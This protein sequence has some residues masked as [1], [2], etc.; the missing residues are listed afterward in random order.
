MMLNTYIIHL[1]KSTA[2]YEYIT[3]LLYRYDFLNVE[4]IDAVDGRL[5]DDY[6]IRKQFNYTKSYHRYGRTLNK[7]EIGCALSHRKCYE[8]IILS[9]NE[10]ALVLEDDISI[11]R[12]LRV[13]ID[14]RPQIDLIMN[15][16][17][18]TICFLSG[19]YWFWEGREGITSVFSAVGAYAYL[20]NKAAARKILEQDKTY[21]VA[22]DWDYVK[23]LKVRYFAIK[24]YIFDANLKMDLLS[25][26]VKQD[27]W[28]VNKKGMSLI[29]LLLH[30]YFQFVKFILYKCHHFESKVRVIDNK[31]VYDKE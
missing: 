10:Y 28:G 15:T 6:S 27:Q 25:T 22:D 20:I 14:L 7:G 24:P 5:M 2:R 17:K 31:A 12:E 11:M 19:D 16:P 13:L 4:Y 3:N 1:K 30:F 8:R 21:T 26:D 29:F 23:V 9:Q 18:P